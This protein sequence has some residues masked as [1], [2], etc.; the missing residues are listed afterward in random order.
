MKRRKI[1][2]NMSEKR[3]LK[4]KRSLKKR[5]KKLRLGKKRTGAYVFGTLRRVRVNPSGLITPDAGVLRIKSTGYY[6]T[7]LGRNMLLRKGQTLDIVGHI[8]EERGG[9]RFM[10]WAVRTPDGFLGYVEKENATKISNKISPNRRRGLRRNQM[11]SSF[12]KPVFGPGNVETRIVRTDTLTGIKEAERLVRDG[13]YQGR[14]GLFTT[15]YYRKR[16]ATPQVA[17]AWKT[18]IYTGKGIAK[19][20][21]K[22]KASP[23]PGKFYRVYWSH[24]SRGETAP[25]IFKGEKLRELNISQLSSYWPL[26]EGLKMAKVNFRGPYDSWDNAF[27]DS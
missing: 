8:Y 16:L 25:L 24:P 11:R 7:N 1:R 15:T 9:K 18:G 13:W 27:M 19:N 5:A 12:D 10:Y 17:P 20:P 21:A 6:D 22:T 26:R 2:R 3:L 14:V 23:I 4:L